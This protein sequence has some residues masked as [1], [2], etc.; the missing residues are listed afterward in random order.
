MENFNEHESE[1]P[2][3]SG[4]ARN[5]FIAPEKHSGPGIASF[6]VSL[7]A[8]IGYIVLIILSTAV[9]AN[10]LA[11]LPDLTIENIEQL[12]QTPELVTVILFV[13]LG[14]LGAF[15]TSL[16]A[17]V[18]GIIGLLQKNRKKAFAITGTI[19][20]G[21]MVG[22]PLLFFLLSMGMGRI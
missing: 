17:L 10:K 18:L 20:S 15:V 22:I 5:E 2:R 11:A 16:I 1:R 19:L 8:G 13:G 14:M 4:Y 9:L 7:L 6:I 21:I 12:Q 3:D